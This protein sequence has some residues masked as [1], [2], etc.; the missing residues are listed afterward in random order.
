MLKINSLREGEKLSFTQYLTVLSV[1]K[2]NNSIIASQ[3]D[4]TPIEI[5]G[6]ELI[7]SM[8]SNSQYEQTIKAGKHELASLLQGAGDKIFTV[9]YL[10]SDKSERVLTGHFVRSEPNLGRTQVIDLNIDPKDKTKGLRLVDNREIKWI[11]L[12]NIKYVSQ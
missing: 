4:G 9:C 2:K 3:T 10:K 6:V 8:Y 7:E 5:Y 12:D 11:V 1:D